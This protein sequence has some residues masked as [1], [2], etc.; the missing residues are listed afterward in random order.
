MSI[1]KYLRGL[2]EEQLEFA[3]AEACRLLEEKLREAKRLVWVVEDGHG[4]REKYFAEA[5]YLLAAECLLKLAKELAPGWPKPMSAVRRMELRIGHMLIPASEYDEFY[6]SMV[7]KPEQQATP[8]ETVLEM[9]EV[10]LSAAGFGGLYVDG[11]CGCKLEELS[12]TVC[13]NTEC[14]PG[15]LHV[16]SDGKAWVICS[17]KKPLSDQE[18]DGVAD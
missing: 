10:S 12:P 15:Y 11:V 7:E 18:I 16:R 8:P 14:T 5:D 9:L 2:N 17:E 3:R 13:L 1:S 6:H 4:S